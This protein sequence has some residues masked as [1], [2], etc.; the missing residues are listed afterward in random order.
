MDMKLKLKRQKQHLGQCS[1]SS[2]SRGAVGG[3]QGSVCSRATTRSRLCRALCQGSLAQVCRE[4]TTTPTWGL[5]LR[6]GPELGAQGCVADG[7][8]LMKLCVAMATGS[9]GAG[10]TVS[11]SGLRLSHSMLCLVEGI[12][13]GRFS[14]VV[15]QGNSQRAC[16]MKDEGKQVTGQLSVSRSLILPL[17]RSPHSRSG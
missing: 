8:V 10:P 15:I 17:L 5:L 6:G 12:I 1:L 3:G 4:F 9:L 16:A 14:G 2:G 13:V 7:Q 11:G